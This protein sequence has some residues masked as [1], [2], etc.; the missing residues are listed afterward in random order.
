MQYATQA[1]FPS[2]KK[3]TKFSLDVFVRGDAYGKKLLS[4]T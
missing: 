2:M 3:N 4:L 1:Y